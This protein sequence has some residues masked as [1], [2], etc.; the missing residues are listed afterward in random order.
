MVEHYS[1]VSA[2][3]ERSGIAKVIG[4]MTVK[5]ASDVAA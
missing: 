1:T 4:L 5:E 2:A 3:E